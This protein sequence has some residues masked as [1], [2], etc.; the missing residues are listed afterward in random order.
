MLIADYSRRWRG[1]LWLGLGWLSPVAAQAQTPPEPTFGERCRGQWAGTMQLYHQGQ[2]RDTVPVQFTVAPLADTAWTWRM[3]YRSVKYPQVKDYVL[4]LLDRAK[5][6]YVVDE[7]GGLVLDDYLIG[8][9]LYSV[10]EVKGNLLTASYELL[11]EQLVFE[12]TAGQKLPDARAGVF[13]YTTVS[14]QRVVLKRV[15]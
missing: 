6:H 13:S 3:E 8:N 9:K 5:G 2:L 7:G 14:V 1:I 15:P 10:F 4:R 12:V 11:G